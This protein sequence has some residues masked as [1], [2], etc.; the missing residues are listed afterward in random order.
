MNNFFIVANKD[1][2]AGFIRT[3]EIRNYL[4][5]KGK[6]C[7]F[8]GI[9]RR[10]ENPTEDAELFSRVPVDT[11]C[12]IV[13]GG[14]GTLIQAAGGLSNRNIPL[15]G[16]NL[17]KLGF[18]AEVD[19]DNIFQAL[20][21]LIAGKYSD[22]EERMMLSGT[23][24]S[25]VNGGVTLSALND[26]VITRKGALRVISFDVFVN[27]RLLTSYTAD[28]MI[29]ATPTGSTGYNLSSGGPIIAPY[30]KNIVV[31]PICAHT[32]LSRS[33]VFTGEDEVKIEIGRRGRITDDETAEIAFDGG[34]CF[35]LR[36][37]D[38]VII[39]RSDDVT[40]IVRLSKESF[41]DILSR[42]MSGVM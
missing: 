8:I 30:A 4:I 15:L 17:G 27:G 12:V 31:T 16:I 14:D 29:V 20:D 35:G 6:S 13:L 18:L 33:L 2:D 22:I 26:I 9:E 40:R 7:E 25:T 38:G 19:K 3:Q 24:F 34:R 1:K 10:Y 23:L 32:L 39:K 5:S 36:M 21:I 28:G 11:D 42:K 37:G 41:L